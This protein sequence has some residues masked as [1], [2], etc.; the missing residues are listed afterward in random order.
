MPKIAFQASPKITAL[1]DQQQW[2]DASPQWATSISTGSG[3]SGTDY[4]R[5]VSTT[6]STATSTN[7]RRTGSETCFSIGQIHGVIDWTKRIVVHLIVRGSGTTNGNA[8]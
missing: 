3:G 5:V 7:L 1:L 2:T 6:G 4:R 8:L